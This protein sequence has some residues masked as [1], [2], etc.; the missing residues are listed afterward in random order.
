MS[1]PSLVEEIVDGLGLGPAQVAKLIPPRRGGKATNP[2]CIWRWMTSGCRV[3]G[4][5]V[6]LENVR[7]GPNRLTSRSAV[8]RFL[9]AMQDPTPPPTPA[10]KPA[11]ARRRRE[12]ERA[13]EELA[14]LGV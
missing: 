6:L 1:S 7:I 11:P 13:A 5:V 9:Q 2:S 10:A 14:D 4:R 8:M 12:V 3:G